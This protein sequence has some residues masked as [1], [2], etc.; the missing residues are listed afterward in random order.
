MK[1]LR[2]VAIR[3]R[4]RSSTA[5]RSKPLGKRNATAQAV[6]GNLGGFCVG[7]RKRPWLASGSHAQL[8]ECGIFQS[9]EVTYARRRLLKDMLCHVKPSD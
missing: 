7:P 1:A 9:V 6:E 2:P 3:L 4:Q 8:L 5:R